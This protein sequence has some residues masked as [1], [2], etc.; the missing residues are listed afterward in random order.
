MQP[1]IQKGNTFII[2]RRK[3][4]NIV[5][6]IHKCTIPPL[7]P[8][9]PF[10]FLIVWTSDFNNLTFDHIVYYLGIPRARSPFPKIFSPSKLYSLHNQILV[11]HR[12]SN[13]PSSA[14]VRYRHNHHVFHS[15]PDI[16]PRMDFHLSPL[17]SH[18]NY[19]G[20]YLGTRQHHFP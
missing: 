3:V 5:V 7:L 15:F 13:V 19:N 1:Q 2:F 8:P 12:K 9:P 20:M 18:R 14:S 10:Q 16:R 17:D 6:E 11:I 4:Y